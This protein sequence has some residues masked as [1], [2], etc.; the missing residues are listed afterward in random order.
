MSKT[1]KSLSSPSWYASV[2][3]VEDFLKTNEK[4]DSLSLKRTRKLESKVVRRIQYLS[5]GVVR[6]LGWLQALLKKGA[7]KFPKKRLQAVMLVSI[8]EWIE[9][10]EQQK[11]KVVHFVV[12]QAKQM[13]SKPES[14][15]VNAVMR[16]LPIL[17]QFEATGNS[18]KT[19][20]SIMSHP[21]WMI[22][23]WKKIF[24]KKTVKQFLEWNQGL[25]K[26]YAF[27]PIPGIVVPN[28]WQPTPWTSFYEIQNADWSV[29]KELLTE[30]KAYIQDPSTRLGVDLSKNHTVESALDLCAAPGGKSVQLL[31]RI[32]KTG[33]LLVSVDLPGTRFDRLVK[34][35]E[36]YQLPGVTALQVAK[37]IL[38]L[39]SEELPQATF[40]LVY[41]DVPCSNTGVLQRRPD[42]KW[43]QTKETL[44]GLIGLQEALL[45]KATE[46]VKK[47]GYIVYSTCSID[48]DENQ[49]VVDRFLESDN[50][51]SLVDSILSYPWESGHD[52]AGVF[53]L[54]K[55]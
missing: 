41:L 33:G 36:S 48:P 39:S 54:W 37:D 16:K 4:L 18:L 26:I 55:N 12:E 45:K 1:E 29:A 23:R 42:V 53:L 9:A 44:R 28:C 3:I 46:F 50:S 15:F 6:N 52:G 51:F 34:N 13:L 21:A 43:R 32:S 11:P 10:D 14:R 27:S 2:R 5:Y 8:Y 40:D 38:Q 35:L 19:H 49:E 25:P 31:H 47:E 17:I 22:K 24:G 30:G 20:S 7:E